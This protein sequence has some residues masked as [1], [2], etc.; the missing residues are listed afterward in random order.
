[1]PFFVLFGTNNPWDE[2]S[3]DETFIHHISRIYLKIIYHV[4]IYRLHVVSTYL[5]QSLVCILGLCISN[6]LSIISF[7]NSS[8]DISSHLKSSRMASN[9][10]SMSL[11]SPSQISEHHFST[12]KTEP[13]A[14]FFLYIFWSP[15]LSYSFVWYTVAS[16]FTRNSSQLPLESF[17]LGHQY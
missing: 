9:T 16:W 8:D 6:H 7:F 3:G 2:S 12:P 11:S 13:S 4:N 1:M 15:F 10:S 17:S 5:V 14:F